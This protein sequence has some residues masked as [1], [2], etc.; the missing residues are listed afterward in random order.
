MYKCFFQAPGN[1]LRAKWGMKPENGRQT[2]L[3]EANHQIE[4]Q[5]FRTMQ[6][7]LP[8]NCEAEGALAVLAVVPRFGAETNS[9]LALVRGQSGSLRLEKDSAN[10][11]PPGR[12]L[13]L[14]LLCEEGN[15]G[16]GQG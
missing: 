10:W 9:P 7:C 8:Q 15:L 1:S 3:L 13:S 5:F 14:K 2:V 11:K 16:L 6:K 12:R 4:H